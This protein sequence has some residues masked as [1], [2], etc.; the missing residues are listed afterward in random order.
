[1]KVLVVDDHPLVREGLKTVTELEDDI[2]IVGFAS[3]VEEGLELLEQNDPDVALVGLRLPGEYGL[4]FVRRARERSRKC[5]Y[6]IL[7]PY[8]TDRKIKRAIAEDVDGYILKEALPEE[9]ISAIR[10][11]GRGEKYYDPEVVRY[12]VELGGNGFGREIPRLT[13]REMEVL[14][15]LGRGLDNRAIARNFVISE[16][17]VN[18]YIHSIFDK[19]EVQNCTQATL[20]AS[21]RK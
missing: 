9:L 19:L 12:S 14:T 5:R 18:H 15:A 16:R 10:L 2:E 11:V 4:N 8:T 7:S 13:R 1:M 21:S 6:V 17:T 20:Y 3:T